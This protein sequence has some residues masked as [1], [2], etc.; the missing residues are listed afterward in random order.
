[1]KY[2]LTRDINPEFY[3]LLEERA[4]LN[5][6]SLAEEVEWLM[7]EAMASPRSRIKMGTWMYSLVPPEYR[8]DLDYEYDGPESPPPDFDR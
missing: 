5:G 1:M 2:L 6:R 7:C 8:C 3:R 4:L